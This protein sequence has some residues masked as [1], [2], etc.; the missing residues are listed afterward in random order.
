MLWQAVDTYLALRRACGYK[1]TGAGYFL[2]SF[3]AFSQAKDQHHV[4]AAT[5]IEWAGLG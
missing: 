4:R 1:L 3:A 2:R 5:A